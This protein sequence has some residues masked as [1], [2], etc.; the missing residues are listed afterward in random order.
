LNPKVISL[1]LKAILKKDEKEYHI[2]DIEA[3]SHIFKAQIYLKLY[4]KSC[5]FM[6]IE[7]KIHFFSGFKN[8]KKG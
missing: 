1:R 8:V 4:E 3:K 2:M 7:A 5:L 6:N